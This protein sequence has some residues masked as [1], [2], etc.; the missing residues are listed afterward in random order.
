[1]TVKKHTGYADLI[2]KSATEARKRFLSTRRNP[3]N[4]KEKD[5]NR[6]G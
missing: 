3:I 1:M 4:I 6:H 5:G 2:S